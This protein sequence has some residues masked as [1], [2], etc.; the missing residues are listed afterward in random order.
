MKMGLR[1]LFFTQIAEFVWKQLQAMLLEFDAASATFLI[2]DLI[3]RAHF[4]DYSQTLLILIRIQKIFDFRNLIL[5]F[6]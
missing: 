6:W 3:R 2:R 1:L 5:L 4:Q